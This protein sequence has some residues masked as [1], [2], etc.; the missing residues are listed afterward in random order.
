MG[1]VNCYLSLLPLSSSAQVFLQYIVIGV[2]DTHSATLAT[3]GEAWLIVLDV[4]LNHM[5]LFRFFKML[6]LYATVTIYTDRDMQSKGTK[7]FLK[8]AVIGNIYA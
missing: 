6:D 2:T 4:M 5:Q 7:S 3:L 1:C 8:I